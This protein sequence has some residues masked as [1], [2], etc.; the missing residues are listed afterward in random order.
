MYGWQ[1]SFYMYKSEYECDV[2]VY[3]CRKKLVPCTITLLFTI[4]LNMVYTYKKS[5]VFSAYHDF[6]NCIIL[7]I[8]PKLEVNILLSNV[9]LIM[10]IYLYK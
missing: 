2:L 5:S 6:W 1:P 10:D 7:Y 3:M 9:Q 4:N 8:I